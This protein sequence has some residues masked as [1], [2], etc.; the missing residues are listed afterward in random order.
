[1]LYVLDQTSAPAQIRRFVSDHE[2][3]FV[4]QIERRIRLSLEPL[5]EGHQTETT[6]TQLF[7]RTVEVADAVASYVLDRCRASE[8]PVCAVRCTY[9]CYAPLEVLWPEA[10]ALARHLQVRLSAQERGRVVEALSEHESSSRGLGNA[11]RYARALA[12]PLL[13]GETGQCAVYP[14][15]PL[16][17]RGANSLH[18]SPCE[19]SCHEDDVD[20]EVNGFLYDTYVAASRALQHVARAANLPAEPRPLSSAL[21]EALERLP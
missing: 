5:L 17:C 18:I 9:C 2:E 20:I 3:T 13:D 15:R 11:E 4:E 16:R 21:R 8:R 10:E 1:M 19:R 6:A 12:C 14:L 7:D